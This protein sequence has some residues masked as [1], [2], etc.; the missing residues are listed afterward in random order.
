MRKV[1]VSFAG[2][3][4]L[5]QSSSVRESRQAVLE[6]ARQAYAAHNQTPYSQ[7]S[8]S[9]GWSAPTTRTKTSSS[10]SDPVRR[11]AMVPNFTSLPS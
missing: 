9:A 11:S 7:S 2:Y 8:V 5:R 6:G 3:V 1:S 4:I 10:V